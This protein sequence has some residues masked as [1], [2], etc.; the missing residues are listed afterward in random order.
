MNTDITI[1]LNQLADKLGTTTELMWEILLK[2]VYIE[3]IEMI[4]FVILT[5]IL[6]FVM[7]KLHKKFT[8]EDTYCEDDS[9]ETG[10]LVGLIATI[11]CVL[12]S[13]VILFM[14]P[15]YII[16]PEYQALEYIFKSLSN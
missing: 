3:L 11:I 14:L 13:I 1:L 12:L 16:N 10:M 5:I 8:R 2:Q 7:Y 15:G 4:S 6:S 9:A